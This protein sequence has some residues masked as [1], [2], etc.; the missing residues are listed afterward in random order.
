MVAFSPA[1]QIFLPLVARLVNDPSSKCRAM[2]GAALAVLLRRAS[3]PRRDRL[4]QYCQQWLAGGDARLNRAAAQVGRLAL[5]RVGR[6]HMGSGAEG[7]QLSRH[8]CCAAG[9]N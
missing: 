7:W 3:A 5:L 8:A 1:L 6:A 4:V 9:S 2:V